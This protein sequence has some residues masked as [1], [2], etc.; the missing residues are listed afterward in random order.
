LKLKLPC[1]PR[2]ITAKHLI[3]SRDHL[4]STLLPNARPDRVTI[5]AH[6]IALLPSL[7]VSVRR[8]KSEEALGSE[9]EEESGEDD[10]AV[11]IFPPTEGTGLVRAVLMGEGTGS[12]P[13]GQ[14]RSYIHATRRMGLTGSRSLP[15]GRE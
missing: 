6:C 4:P 12:C 11:V 10:T 9:G 13:S 8:P 5:T 1:H 2:V 7:P 14:C 15:F 3:S